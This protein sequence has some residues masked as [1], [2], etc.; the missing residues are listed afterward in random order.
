[1]P[2]ITR[3]SM[4]GLSAAAL[5]GCATGTG[6]PKSTA[7]AAGPKVSANEKLNI[8]CVGVGGQGQA[9]LRSVMH[10]N[11]VA[12]CD[13]DSERAAV[14]YKNL[15]DI[16]KYNDYRVML[17]KQKD[18]DAVV[19]AI[20]DHMHAFVATAAM[21]LGKHVY[22]EKPMAHSIAE[23]H[24]LATTANEYKV[25][26][27]MGNQGHSMPGVW[28]LCQMIDSGMIGPV[29]EVH[30]WTNRP[31]WPQGLE[32]PTD[33]PPIPD[34]L[35]WEVWLGGALDRPYHP[36]YAPH[37]WRGWWDF[38]C[39]AMGDMGCHILDPPYTS[40]KLGAPVRLSTETSGVNDETGPLWSIITFEFPARGDMPPV[41]LTWFDGGKLPPRPEGLAPDYKLGDKDGG[42]ILIGEK[43]SITVGTYGNGPRFLDP[44]QQQEWEANAPERPTATGHHRSWIEACKGG[45]PSLSNF[46]YAAPFTEVVLLGNIAI[47]AQQPIEWNTASKQ[48]TNVPE[49]NR[50]VDMPYREG[51]VL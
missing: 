31:T 19:I 20:P 2:L 41:K 21:Q 39:C 44:A 7:L 13:V 46:E 15:P 26:T 48:V 50:F 38:G 24:K 37:K 11:V 29:H 45:E 32:R 27:Q 5:A 4:L 8:A 9:D 36:A 25:A 10:E 43:G 17:E 14:T 33:T 1:M 34:T 28:A 12:L 40:L 47:R 16:P 6:T 30:S 49:A 3:R 22:V 51:W 23:V 42:S 18:I 35:N